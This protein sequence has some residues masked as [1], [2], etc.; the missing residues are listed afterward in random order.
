VA[1]QIDLADD[2]GG[3]IPGV[4]TGLWENW[5]RHWLGRAALARRS[6][7]RDAKRQLLDLRRLGIPKWLRR[8]IVLFELWRAAPYNER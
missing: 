4:S 2:R 1:Y 3:H 6:P 5:A 7:A 8:P